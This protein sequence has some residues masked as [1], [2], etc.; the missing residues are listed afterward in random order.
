MLSAVGASKRSASIAAGSKTSARRARFG[1]TPSI[2]IEL[3]LTW[4][5]GALPSSGKGFPDPAAGTE[6]QPAFVGNDDLRMFSLCQVLLHLVG[7][8]MDIDDRA[9]NSGPCEP[10]QHMVDERLARDLHQR[11]RNCVRERTHARAEPGCQNHGAA[12]NDLS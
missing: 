1:F 10:V 7:E 5:K 12:R 8:I 11:F 6:Q 4:K 2:Q 9:L 3:E